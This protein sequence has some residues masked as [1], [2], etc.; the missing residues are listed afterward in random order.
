MNTVRVANRIS[1]SSR[2]IPSAYARLYFGACYFL[3]GQPAVACC[4]RTRRALS[5]IIGARLV[6]RRSVGE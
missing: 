3:G 5:V 1:V 4:E 2:F 6:R